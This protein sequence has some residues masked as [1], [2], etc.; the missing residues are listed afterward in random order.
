MTRPA[1]LDLAQAKRYA[2]AAREE[3]VTVEIETTAGKVRFLPEIHSLSANVPVDGPVSF[4]S[5]ADYKAW[6]DGKDARRD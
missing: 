5:L 6:R 4:E 1:S 3:G 2:R